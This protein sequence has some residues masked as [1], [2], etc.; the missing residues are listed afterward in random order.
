MSVKFSFR[1]VNSNPYLSPHKSFVLIK[2]PSYQRCVVVMERFFDYWKI[3]IF[4]FLARKC[5]GFF[6]KKI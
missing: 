5:H 1:G 4:P 2:Y 6:F 3:K